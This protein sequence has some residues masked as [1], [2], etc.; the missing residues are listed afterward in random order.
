[1]NLKLL[2]PLSFLLVNALSSSAFVVNPT[3]GTPAF[4]TKSSTTQFMTVELEPEPEGGE[5]ISALTVMEGSRIKNMGEC[6]E[7][8]SENGDTVYNF[9]MTAI[10]DGELVKKLRTQVSKDAARN[11]NFPGFRKGQIPPYAQPQ[12]TMF[13]VQEG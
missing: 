6:S 9:W 2:T 3:S 4:A 5:E 12:M 11:A 10:A 1:M 13:A 8:K 7:T